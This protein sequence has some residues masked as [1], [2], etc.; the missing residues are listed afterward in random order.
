M[1]MDTNGE[2]S[3]LGKKVF[4]LY[5]PSVVRDEVVARLLE[6]EFE[7]YM[8]RDHVGMRRL[9]ALYP[10]S[11]VFINLDEGQNE[12]EWETWIREILADPVTGKVGIG[13]ISYNTDEKLQRKYLMDVGI[14]C[15]FIRLKLGVE[16]SA[17]IL[18]EMLK[19]NEA[20][21]RRKY[22]RANCAEDSMST[23]N[24]HSNTGLI[25]G[26]IRDISVVGFSCS[27]DQDPQFPKNAKLT[28]IQLKLR[29]LL[30]RAEG[31]VYGT[32]EDGG[33]VYVVLFTKKMDGVSR[34]KI[35]RYIQTTL[36]SEIEVQAK[37]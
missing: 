16:E 6:Q 21:G 24:L 30:V 33:T 13:I 14:R 3:L 17:R 11:L 4:F 8:L 31:I 28:D 23:V 37:T 29:G 32:R 2:P 19:A 5:P 22:V 1:C 9:L 35:R 18:L 36:Q 27:F 20:K 34:S 10:D 15:G 7:I 26:S 12:G 25:S